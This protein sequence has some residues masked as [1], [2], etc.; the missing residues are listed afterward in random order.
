MNQFV[1][2]TVQVGDRDEVRQPE[3]IDPR[4]DYILFSDQHIG[5][6]LGVWQVRGFDYQNDDPT[7]R[8]RYPKILPHR[9][10]SD[11]DASLYIDANISIAKIAS[12]PHRH[13]AV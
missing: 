4:F 11:Y 1:I 10:L 5:E 8:S 2:Y 6:Q 9:L 3:I 12:S 7:I 13:F